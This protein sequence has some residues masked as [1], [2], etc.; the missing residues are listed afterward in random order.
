MPW[1]RKASPRARATPRPGCGCSTAEC[2]RGEVAS[3]QIALGEQDRRR[4]L[5]VLIVL[6]A[7]AVTFVFRHQIPHGD[8]A[9]LEGGDHLL[10][11]AARDAGVVHALHNE[12][13]LRDL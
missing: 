2:S 10:G 12:E 9:P 11:L 8:A 3:Q 1:R 13:R 6:L 5:K 4:K 7:E